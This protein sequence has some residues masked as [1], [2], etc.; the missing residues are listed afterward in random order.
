M[1]TMADDEPA[2]L[3]TP[4]P[5]VRLRVSKRTVQ[6]WASEGRITARL[7]LPDGARRWNLADVERELDEAT[8]R[9]R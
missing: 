6:R 1:I 7:T 3:M 5:T 9:D 4:E 2:L 8:E